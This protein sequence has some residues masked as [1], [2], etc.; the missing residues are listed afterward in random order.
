[1]NI[2]HSI[3]YAIVHRIHAYLLRHSLDI[4]VLALTRSGAIHKSHQIITDHR[5][6]SNHAQDLP[7][8]RLRACY[9]QCSPNLSHP[10]RKARHTERGMYMNQ[11]ILLCSLNDTL[12]LLFSTGRIYV[13]L[14][15]G[16]NHDGPKNKTGI[17]LH[18]IPHRSGYS[19][20]RCAL[21]VCWTFSRDSGEKTK[22][23]P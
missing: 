21:S 22:N 19:S 23:I 2:K 6:I 10:L 15:C 14:R 3:F 9:K 4:C 7:L 17:F 1:M 11:V 16:S 18:R 13:L 12:C 20:D 8:S 5:H